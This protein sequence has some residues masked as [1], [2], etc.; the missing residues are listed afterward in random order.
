[1]LLHEK[2]PAQI[3]LIYVSSFKLAFTCWNNSGV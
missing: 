1:M 2:K 3:N